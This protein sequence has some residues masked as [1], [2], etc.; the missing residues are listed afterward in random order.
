MALKIVMVVRRS[1]KVE[2]TKRGVKCHLVKVSGR[3]P[4][5]KIKLQTIEQT[6]D[7]V[8][9]THYDWND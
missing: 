6:N 9:Q 5:R 4:K 7:Q 8:K 1:D 3:A 2:V